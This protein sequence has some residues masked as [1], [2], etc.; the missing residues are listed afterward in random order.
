LN[1][2]GDNIESTLLQLTSFIYF[3]DTLF[4]N[5]DEEQ[6]AMVFKRSNEIEKKSHSIFK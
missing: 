3:K 2:W 6:K 4:L 1:E 5:Y